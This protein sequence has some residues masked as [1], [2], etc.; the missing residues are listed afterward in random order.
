MIMAAKSHRLLSLFLE[1]DQPIENLDN[2]VATVDDMKAIA[3]LTMEHVI[4]LEPRSL[5]ENIT[6]KDVVRKIIEDTEV[7]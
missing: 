5:G 4:R 7:L 6:E 1:S 2:I 3:P